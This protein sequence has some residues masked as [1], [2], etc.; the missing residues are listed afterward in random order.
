MYFMEHDDKTDPYPLPPL[1]EQVKQFIEGNLSVGPFRVN[2]VVDL[3]NSSAS[4][5][6]KKI[7]TIFTDD[8][9]KSDWYQ[10]KDKME[11]KKRFQT[12]MDYLIMLYGNTMKDANSNMAVAA[13]LSKA[14]RHR[15]KL[16]VSSI[17]TSLFSHCLRTCKIHPDLRRHVQVLENLGVDGMSSDESTIKDDECVYVIFKK[18]WRSAAVT[19]WLLDIDSVHLNL[20]VTDSGCVTGGN[21]PCS[22]S[23]HNSKR[24]LVKGLSKTLYNADWLSTPEKIE[25][26]NAHSE[27]YDLS[28][29]DTIAQYVYYF[30]CYVTRF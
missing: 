28:H 27:L 13:R 9:V 14:T 2:F 30:L 24:L 29:S 19:L 20:R 5:W 10:F 26:L 7:A 23:M 11:I 4:A 18:P 12:H 25:D 6:N 1:P 22:D 16:Q 21:W 15:Q 8:F 17:N 3:A